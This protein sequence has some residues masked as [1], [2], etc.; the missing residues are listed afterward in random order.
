M[1]MASMSQQLET[2][3]FYGSTAADPR[4]MDGLATQYNLKSGGTG[5][6]IIDAGGTLSA[7][8]SAF[9][10]GWGNDSVFGVYPEGTAGGLLVKDLGV[11]L[12]TDAAGN[13]YSAF[14]TEFKQR[15]GLVIKDWR[16]V[17][18]I[19]NLDTA[20]FKTL[21][22]T[23]ATTAYSTNL[24]YCIN[25][26]MALLPNPRAVKMELYVN[27]STEALLIS[28]ATAGSSNAVSF[29]DAMTQF[30][31]LRQLTVAGIP[32]RV[33]DAILNTEA[34]VV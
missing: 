25:R 28:L 32:V 27:R 2:V 20:V 3:L 21:T 11:Q 13:Q 8:S 33:S 18:R 9:L 14:V 7:N 24:I 26:A 19:A 23:Q 12:V 31:M 30:G 5:T 10:V 34:R 17:V 22:G 16:N 6:N 29:V 15:L 4:S 1:Y